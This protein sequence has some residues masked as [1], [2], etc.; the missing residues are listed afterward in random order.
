[1][2]DLTNQLSIDNLFWRIVTNDDEKAFCSLFYNFF[3]SLCVFAGRYIDNK[4]ECEDIVQDTF[5]KIWRTRKSLEITSSARNLL[6]TTVK[7]SCI[8]YLRKKEVEHTYIE[9]QAKKEWLM[10]QDD[11]YSTMELEE[12]I[13][14]ALSQLPE[15]LRQVF[16]MNRFD[17]LTYAQIAEKQ[18]ISVKTVEAYMSKSL[19]MMRTELKDYLPLILLFCW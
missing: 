19:K 13:S 4:E 3:P 1:M 17:G 15:N 2:T 12:I 14:R 6:V 7:N 18:N 10:Y 8:D 11:V 16:E 5:F 9:R